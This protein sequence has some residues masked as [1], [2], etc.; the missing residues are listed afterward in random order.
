M[1]LKK[2]ASAGAKAAAANRA[3]AGSAASAV[4]AQNQKTFGTS[5]A[6]KPSSS[7][8][9]KTIQ[10]NGQTITATPYSQLNNSTPSSLKTTDTS[11]TNQ[12]R[13]INSKTGASA[14]TLGGSARASQLE[15]QG[16][17]LEGAAPKATDMAVKNLYGKYEDEVKA[18]ANE[19]FIRNADLGK[20]LGLKFE[21]SAESYMNRQL[22]ERQEELDYQ[23]KLQERQDALEDSDVMRAR[24][25]AKANRAGVEQAYGSNREGIMSAGNEKAVDQYDAENRRQYSNLQERASIAQEERARAVQGLERA[26]RDQNYAMVDEY[27]TRLVAADNK[28]R[29][30][31]VTDANIQESIASTEK[32]KQENLFTNLEVLG[33]SVANLDT[34]QLQVMGENAGISLP[35]MVNLQKAYQLRAE[36]AEMKD[37]GAARYAM[38]QADELIQSV[39]FQQEDRPL[40]V[41]FK[42]AETRIKEAEANGVILNPLDRL[43]YA[44]ALAEYTD[45]LGQGDVYLPSGTKYPVTPT[46]TGISVGVKEGDP[47]G[48]CGAFV[49]DVLGERIIGN[50]YEQKI[51]L[52][53]SQTPVVGAVGVMA[54]PG[55]YAKYGHVVIVEK[56]NPDGTLSIVES[57]GV[58]ANGEPSPMKASRRKIPVTSFDG[59][60]IPDSS[61]L[62]NTSGSKGLTSYDV[63]VFNSFD[64]K[65]IPDSWT[66][67]KQSFIEQYKTFNNTKKDPNTDLSTLLSMTN[68]GKALTTGA[69]EQ[70]NKFD[71]TNEQLNEIESS[72]GKVKTDKLNPLLSAI[73]SKNPYATKVQAI[74]AQLQAIIP[75]LA[76]G[77]Y[78]EVGVLTDQDIENYRKT[79]PNLKQTKDVQGLVL[80]MT[81]KIIQRGAEKK[82]RSLASTYDISGYEYLVRDLVNPM[83]VEDDEISGYLKSSTN[84]PVAPEEDSL[85]DNEINAY[86]NNR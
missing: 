61:K 35:Q 24:D 40:D 44:Q 15:R 18:Q 45:S 75:G 83:E 49:N 20:E 33:S 13:Y 71:M 65:Q 80:D 30:S 85:I 47:T 55:D 25:V 29:E 53:N 86:F 38:A 3:K 50:S 62:V 4:K 1:A 36:A 43:E 17:T 81:R 46:G 72:L 12:V 31:A 5:T 78:G 42:E 60:I 63:A 22:Q 66:G 82:L 16:Y 84:K 27:R 74:N 32:L 28:I 56:I 57:N 11:A 9:S 77:V 68:G 76:R 19:P 6:S 37:E 52:I 26:I 73:N 59:F 41:R 69:E 48:W 39:K 7:S 14:S 21:T 67:S 23:R 2:G 34:T 64:G 79:I 70:L 51:S 54:S 58:K 8:G 10:L